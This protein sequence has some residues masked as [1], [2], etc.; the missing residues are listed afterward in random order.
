VLF[1]PARPARPGL[2]AGT[3][4]AEDRAVGPACAGLASRGNDQLA[5][6]EN[7]EGAVDE[8]TRQRPDRAELTRRRQLSSQCP[9]V[10]GPLTEQRKNGP[11]ARGEIAF[12]HRFTLRGKVGVRFLQRVLSAPFHSLAH[13]LRCCRRPVVHRIY[14]GTAGNRTATRTGAR[15]T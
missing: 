11:F 6:L 4:R 15:S 10:G 13:L 5:F 14:H 9:A 3:R 8:G 2:V 7:L 1:R 12:A